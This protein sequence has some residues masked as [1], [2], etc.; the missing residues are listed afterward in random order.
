VNEAQVFLEVTSWPNHRLELPG[1]FLEVT[2][3][4]DAA[5]FGVDTYLI[6]VCYTRLV[7]PTAEQT[8]Y[9][10]HAGCI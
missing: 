10:D 6:D 2:E 4:C 9:H 3:Q 5:L 8:R 1:S 7:I